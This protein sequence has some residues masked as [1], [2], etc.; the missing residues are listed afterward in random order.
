MAIS[1]TSHHTNGVNVALVDGSVRF[2][3]ETIQT[4]SAG[5]SYSS[6]NRYIVEQ[7]S[8]NFGIWGAYGAINDGAATPGL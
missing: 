7:G 6:T 4:L 3:P 2:I 8:S 1:A 5:V